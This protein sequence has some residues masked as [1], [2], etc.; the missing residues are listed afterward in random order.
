[1]R[2]APTRW[3]APMRRREF[4]TLAGGMAVWPLAA[5]AQHQGFLLRGLQV[6]VLPGSPIFSGLSAILADQFHVAACRNCSPLVSMGYKQWRQFRA[7]WLRQE[8]D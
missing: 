4:I 5:R 6:R 7:T 1:M 3:I 2:P 8:T